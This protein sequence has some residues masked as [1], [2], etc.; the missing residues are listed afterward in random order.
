MTLKSRLKRFI[1]REGQFIFLT[2]C[3][4]EMNGGGAGTDCV[5]LRGPDGYQGDYPVLSREQGQTEE[6][7]Q[8]AKTDFMREVSNA[9][10]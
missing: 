8:Q 9:N 4:D 1:E 5:L 10:G 2:F 6:E 7:W 3:G